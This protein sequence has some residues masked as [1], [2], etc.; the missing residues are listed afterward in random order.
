MPSAKVVF[1]DFDRT[2]AFHPSIWNDLT[3]E[4]LGERNPRPTPTL[5]EIRPFLQTGFPWHTPEIA[6][7]ELD[8]PAKWWERVEK[9]ISRAYVAFGL[10][11]NLADELAA[12]AH[13]R[14][15][16]P[17]GY[18]VYDDSFPTLR[19][20]AGRGWRHFI[21]SNHVPELPDI[22]PALGLRPLVE[23]VITSANIGYEKPHREI[24]RLALDIAG[25]PAVAWMVGDNVIADVMGAEAAGIKRILVRGRDERAKR[26][27][28]DLGSVID[29]V[30]SEDG[31]PA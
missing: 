4:V 31:R 14:W 17:G 20:L 2:L 29:R 30:A 3:A 24:F 19:E 23:E 7:P 13:R 8:S 28:Q 27:C 15:I 25:D 5:A 6:H 22:A 18:V 10:P 12:E 11:E 1:W 21:L 9:V 26:N 16:D